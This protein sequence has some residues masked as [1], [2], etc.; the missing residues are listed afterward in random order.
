VHGIAI[1]LDAQKISYRDNLCSIVSL[2]W[3]IPYG[4]TSMNTKVK[5][6]QLRGWILCRT[7][8]ST[9][10]Y[11]RYNPHDCTPSPWANADTQKLWS[12]YKISCN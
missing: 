8:I 3:L 2:K 4:E 10:W 11:D 7:S 9:L 6:T 12:P 1:T 5:T